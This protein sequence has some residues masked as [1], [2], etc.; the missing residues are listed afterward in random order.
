MCI[1]THVRMSYV[2]AYKTL[3]C[4]NNHINY[5]ENIEWINLGALHWMND[6]TVRNTYVYQMYLHCAQLHKGHD[7][8]I[9]ATGYM[10][11]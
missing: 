11:I 8:A 10:Y 3:L 4:L 2:K 1:R 5:T 9:E 6:S 7:G